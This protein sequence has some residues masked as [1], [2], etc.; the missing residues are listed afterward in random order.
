MKLKNLLALIWGLGFLNM[1]I[2]ELV[3]LAT[4]KLIWN[5]MNRL[6]VHFFTVKQLLLLV[7]LIETS[8]GAFFLYQLLKGK[9]NR[10]SHIV[11]AAFTLLVIIVLESASRDYLFF[12]DIETICMLL[13]MGLSLFW[14]PIEAEVVA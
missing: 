2:A 9:I 8:V 11:G 7:L 6:D 13:L 14:K 10:L 4:P 1:A 12:G 3:T 5:I